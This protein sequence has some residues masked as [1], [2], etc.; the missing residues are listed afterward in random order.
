MQQGPSKI[1]DQIDLFTK[2]QIEKK[3]LLALDLLKAKTANSQAIVLTHKPW[4][5]CTHLKKLFDLQAAA[6]KTDLVRLAE[7][8]RLAKKHNLPTEL[9]LLFTATMRLTVALFLPRRWFRGGVL[10]ASGWGG[11]RRWTAS[12]ALLL[13][14]RVDCFG[15]S[16]K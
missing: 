10:R 13:V 9:S 11:S 1:E 14:Q 5:T 6:L 16:D 3:R 2:W 15:H 8:L 7:D 12:R 4:L